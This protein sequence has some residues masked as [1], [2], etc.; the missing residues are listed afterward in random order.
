MFTI[1]DFTAWLLSQ[2]SRP[3]PVGELA[4]TVAR[5][6]SRGVPLPIYPWPTTAACAN[7]WRSYL[8]SRHAEPNALAALEQALIDY[9]AEFVAEPSPAMRGLAQPAGAP[10]PRPHLA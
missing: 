2:E 5:D 4:A 1:D 8:Y 9:R 6:L 7:A 10:L 3:D